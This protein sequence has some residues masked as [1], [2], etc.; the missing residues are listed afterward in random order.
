MLVPFVTLNI[1]SKIRTLG[2]YYLIRAQS[3]QKCF[4]DFNYL[5]IA[6]STLDIN[7]KF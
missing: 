3:F 5:K 2:F 1:R 4:F 6:N 7:G